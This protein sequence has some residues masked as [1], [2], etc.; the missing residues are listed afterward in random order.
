MKQAWNTFTTTVRELATDKTS[1]DMFLFLM[2]GI[3][4]VILVAALV[5]NI[6]R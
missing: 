1:R 2:G 6:K 3:A 5:Y 4:V